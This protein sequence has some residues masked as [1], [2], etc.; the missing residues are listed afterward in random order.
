MVV[1]CLDIV[2]QT[3][4]NV[5]CPALM[6]EDSDYPEVRKATDSGDESY[7]SDEDRDSS[8]AAVVAQLKETTAKWRRD[9]KAIMKR[10]GTFKYT[11][12]QLAADHNYGA[13]R[14]ILNLAEGHTLSKAVVKYMNRSIKARK[15]YDNLAQLLEAGQQQE[16]RAMLLGGGGEME[17]PRSHSA[18]QQQHRGSAP[19]SRTGGGGG[20]GNHM[21]NVVV[22]AMIAANNNGRSNSISPPRGRSDSTA[23]GSAATLSTTTAAAA[24]AMGISSPMV[25]PDASPVLG[26][27]GRR[28]ISAALPVVGLSANSCESV[29]A[30][31]SAASYMAAAAAVA[32]MAS[33]ATSTAT[34]AAAR[35]A[36]AAS[37]SH[38]G[39]AAGPEF[40]FHDDDRKENNNIKAFEGYYNF[41]TE[42]TNAGGDDVAEKTSNAA[43][44]VA[45]NVPVDTGV[46]ASIE[47]QN[48]LIKMKKEKA[49]AV[50]FLI[51]GDSDRLE[52]DDDFG[53]NE[54][55]GESCLE[56]S[57]LLSLMPIF[58]KVFLSI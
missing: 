11:E 27:R 12:T 26:D 50:S 6:L 17:S 44:A 52:N 24:V 28:K 1:R 23:P 19:P 10:H 57:T 36:I 9:P 16:H 7:Y 3:L 4:H 45:V 41:G 55:G 29:E 37:H 8:S 49:L 34:A 5:L 18:N 32:A 15:T 38:A 58:L 56:F 22:Q 53:G 21:S 20:G 2:L 40:D 43:V 54:G 30:A 48:M 31:A 42:H 14:G 47:Y 13:P 39:Y 35:V 33:T 51:K 46:R 25:S